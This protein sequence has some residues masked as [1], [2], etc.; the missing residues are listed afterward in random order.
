M[1]K[2]DT[3]EKEEVALKKEIKS[4]GMENLALQGLVSLGMTFSHKSKISVQVKRA[5]EGPTVPTSD[6]CYTFRFKDLIKTHKSL[7]EIFRYQI[8]G[9]ITR[10]LIESLH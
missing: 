6:I 10:R 3:L 5:K 9:R 4:L 2:V 7:S 1:Y 8:K